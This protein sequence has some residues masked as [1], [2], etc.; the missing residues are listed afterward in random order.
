MII[1]VLRNKYK[2]GSGR[3]ITYLDIPEF[4]IKFNM[5]IDWDLCTFPYK[6]DNK[7]EQDKKF[8][9]D[10]PEIKVGD[11]FII[12]GGQVCAFESQDRLVL[13]ISESG[14]MALKR[15]YNEKVAIEFDLKLNYLGTKVEFKNI[16]PDKIPENVDIYDAPYPIMSLFKDR[17][18]LGRPEYKPFL[19]VTMETDNSIIPVHMYIADWK[20][21]FDQ[22]S[23]VSEEMFE[24]LTKELIAWF[25]NN[26]P[27]LKIK[28]SNKKS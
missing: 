23:C 26:Y 4:L 12:D 27:V 8:L 6:L 3:G 28:E 21:L 18:L 16:E 7:D 17:F 15:L 11:M 1:T 5:I 14:Y 2:V 19:E 10:T 25:Y 24:S 9:G 20:I 22:K 13:C